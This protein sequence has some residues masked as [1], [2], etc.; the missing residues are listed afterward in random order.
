MSGS[1]VQIDLEEAEYLYWGLGMTLRELANIFYVTHSTVRLRFVENGIPTRSPSER[2]IHPDSRRAEMI[3]LFD[4]GMSYRDIDRHFGLANG[5][6]GK[7]LRRIG[8]RRSRSEANRI[9]QM[10]RLARLG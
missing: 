2:L 8:V 4:S 7:R 9:G 5:S 10:A 3:A 1:K 6:T